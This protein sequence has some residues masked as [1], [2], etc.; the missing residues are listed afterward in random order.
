MPGFFL[1]G[2]Q[3]S[4]N[5]RLKGQVFSLFFAPLYADYFR[6]KKDAGTTDKALW[7]IYLAL[8]KVAFRVFNQRMREMVSVKQ[9][10]VYSEKERKINTRNDPGIC[11]HCGEYFKKLQQHILYKHTRLY[12][13]C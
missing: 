3:N 1:E 10:L 6:K 2:G 4:Q 11:P 8:R 5:V 13:F 9:L 12:K 7:L